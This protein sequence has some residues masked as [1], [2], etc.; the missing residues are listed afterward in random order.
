MTAA[1]WATV[2][3]AKPL[4]GALGRR[5]SLPG[6]AETLRADQTCRSYLVPCVVADSLGLQRDLYYA[7]YVPAVVGVSV[8][9]ARDTGQALTEMVARHWRLA[10]GLGLL[11]AGISVLI[12]RASRR[13]L[14]ASGGPTLPAAIGWRGLIY[15]AADG[16]L[17]SASRSCCC[18]RRCAT[19]ACAA[20][21][22][23]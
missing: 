16:L 19:V 4:P 1:D 11:F 20:A 21:P 5:F 15:G 12:A 18:S 10:P 23:G 7:V 9:C 13:L 22:A 8:G 17:L 2:A 14:A 3:G 6:P